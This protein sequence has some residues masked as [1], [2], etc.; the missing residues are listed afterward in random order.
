MKTRGPEPSRESFYMDEY[1]QR[2]ACKFNKQG[3]KHLDYFIHLFIY[4]GARVA[5]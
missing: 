4:S 1:L 2:F 5:P 3:Q